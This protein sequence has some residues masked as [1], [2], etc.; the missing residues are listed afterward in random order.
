MFSSR[1]SNVWSVNQSPLLGFLVKYFTTANFKQ[2]QDIT[3]AGLEDMC[4]SALCDGGSDTS[5]HLQEHG[6]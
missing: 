4:N 6:P 1:L 5:K 2:P 3:N